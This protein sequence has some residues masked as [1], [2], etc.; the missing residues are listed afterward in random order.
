MKKS[1]EIAITVKNLD[2][3]Y[4]EVK[5]FSIK[6]GELKKISGAKVFHAVKNVSFDVQKGEIIGICGKNGSGKSTLLRAIAGIFLLIMVILIYTI[7][8]FHSY[9]L[10]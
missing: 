7:I 9:Q 3:M 8:L 1:K 5:S 2:I 6:R 4:K 10:E